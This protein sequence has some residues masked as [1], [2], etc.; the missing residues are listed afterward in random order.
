MAYTPHSE[1]D[2]SEMLKSCGKEKIEDFFENI[3]KELKF[4]GEFNIPSSMSEIELT[5]YF[6]KLASKNTI[7]N[8]NFLGAGSY[9]HFIP[10]AV[11]SIIS[12]G[13]FFTAYTPYQAEASQGTLQAIYEFQSY[14]T[15]LTGT[16][17]ANAS[18]YDG[19]T[20]L[21]EAVIIA[22]AET[23]KKKVVAFNGVHPEYLETL[24]TYNGKQNI[25]TVS[26][27]ISSLQSVIDKDTAAVVVQSPNFFGCIEDIAKISEITKSMK[28]ILIVVINELYSAGILK[29]AGDLGADIVVGD[30]QSF[31]NS[32]AFGGPSLGFIGVKSKYMRKIPGRICGQTVDSEGN[33]G[34]VLTLQ[35]REQHI[36]REKSSS[37]I[38]SNQALCALAATVNL[39]LIG[40]KGIREIAMQNMQKAHYAAEKIAALDGFSLKFTQPFF[41][42]FT[43]K[44]EGIKAPDLINM[45]SEKGIACGFNLGRFYKNMDDCL[46]VCVTEMA[47]REMI[48]EF[49]QE[50]SNCM[51]GAFVNV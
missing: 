43:V 29:T 31:G 34:Y 18:L 35:A 4:K 9:N 45:M 8:M 12:K 38:C 49:V 19:A 24:A 17:V 41:N 11:N 42:E 23:R 51:K 32:T 7:Y 16:D 26:S 2:I 39:S 14:I 50:L 3:P 20:A 37:N 10:A 1:Q 13:E 22:C 30:A 25:I 40:K 5:R 44:C 28:V 21:C 47:T 15:M 6:D 48:D 46:L 27:D 33:I 36:R